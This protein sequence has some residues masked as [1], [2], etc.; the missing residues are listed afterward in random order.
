[1]PDIINAPQPEKKKYSA[2]DKEGAAIWTARKNGDPTKDK[3]KIF[4]EKYKTA[5]KD[6]NEWERHVGVQD[7][8]GMVTE[9]AEEIIAEIEQSQ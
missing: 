1:M 4:E 9:K 7:G 5:F 8:K 6:F 2:A 3:I